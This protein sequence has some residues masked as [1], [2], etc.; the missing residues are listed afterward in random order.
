MKP[1]CAPVFFDRLAARQVGVVLVLWVASV[2]AHAADDYVPQ[3]GQFPPASAGVSL[4]GELISVDHVNRRGAL[5]L[6]GDGVD[7]RYHWAPPHKFAVLPYGVIRY[8]GAP[9]ELK[10]IPLGT[11]LHG[12]FVLPPAGDTTIPA[13]IEGAHY[14]P[15]QNHALLLE[16]DVSFY[17]RQEQSWRIESVDAKQ[18]KL[19]VTS[20]GKSVKDGLTGEQLFEFDGSTRVWKG[21]QFGELAD[22]AAG[23]SVQV[24]L[25]W[26]PEWKNGQLHLLDV[27]LDDDSLSIAAERQ[28]QV[29][30]R[31]EQVHGIPA[32]IDDV[33]HQPGGKGIITV[34]LFAGR[35]ASLTDQVKQ[36]HGVRIAAAESTLRTW[37]GDHDYKHCQVLE[38]KQTDQPPSGSSGIQVRLECGELLEGFRPTRI[39]RVFPAHWPR[40]KLPPE[41]RV[42]SLEDR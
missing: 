4:T 37:W 26:A 36:G 18:G 34:T 31:Y 5:R 6:V 40:I 19:K 8:H 24:N 29:H 7:D 20:V 15:K 1:H 2:A 9:A 10:D 14:V 13:V 32:W 38:R 33:Q 27:W 12:R 28:R 16:D 17:R 11:V 41:E 23:Q 35:D 22:L 42:K 3:P 30:L 25:G 21:K 39:V